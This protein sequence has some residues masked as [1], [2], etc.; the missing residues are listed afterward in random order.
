LKLDVLLSPKSVAVLGAS[1]EPGDLGHRVA[2]NLCTGGFGGEV[3]LVHPRGGEIDG[4]PVVTELGQAV[5]L[6]VV[7]TPAREVREAVEAALGA[8][9]QAIQVNT[10]LERRVG[11]EQGE[12][13]RE[14][15]AACRARGVRLLGPSSLGVVNRALGLNATFVEHLPPAGSIAVVSQ[16]SALAAAILDWTASRGVGLSTLIALG[17]KLDLDEIDVFEHLLGD[18]V[19]KVVIGYLEYIRA[20]R[21]FLKVAESL[22]SIKPVILLKTGST[23]AGARAS[24]AHLG[25]APATDMAYGAAFKR[26]GVVRADSFQ[27]LLDSARALVSQPLPRGP[28]M[29]VVTN[30]GGPGIMA[31]DALEEHGMQLATLGEGTLAS[32]RKVLPPEAGVENPVDVLGDADP[33]RF[34]EALRSVQADPGV[35]GVLLVLAPQAATRPA[36]TARALV[37]SL[38][39][40]KPT[41]AAFMGGHEVVEAR[42]VLVAAGVPDFP[43][44][45]RAARSLGA[46]CE[47][48]TWRRRPPRVVTRYPVNRRRVERILRR[49]ER[50][51]RTEVEEFMAKEVLAAYDFSIPEGHL[52][53]TADEAVEAAERLGY[54]VVL[55]IVSPDIVQKSSVGGVRLG[56]VNPEQVSDAFDLIMLRIQKQRP[57]AQIDGLVVEKMCSRGLE[58]VVGMTRDPE[59]GPLLMF[60]LGGIA[61]EVMEDVAFYLAPITEDEALQML[62]STRSF[63]TIEARK[64]RVG[65]DVAAIASALQR[66]SQLAT[67][68]PQV[69][70]VEISPFIVGRPGQESMVADARLVIAKGVAP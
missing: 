50:E 67:D 21:D 1:P 30:A 56:L 54:P 65:M 26:S 4:R 22:S 3:V 60:G 34:A 62:K 55:K 57:D 18:P 48:A 8:G 40:T 17:N 31:A 44:P 49:V 68:F 9:A 5:D 20:G 69:R 35:D 11:S 25:E 16:S 32:L 63:Q 12:L 7:A 47:Y 46:L 36:E 23:G 33:A 29:A 28:R 64:A 61:V 70:E 6:A 37:A 51:G 58:V 14:L 39:R 42:Q 53:V 24:A 41:L 45:H 27:M 10:P 15:L 38:D 13:E 52:V 66:L 2:H 43:A 59:F 19:T